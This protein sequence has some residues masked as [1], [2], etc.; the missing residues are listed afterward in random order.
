M[1]ADGRLVFT[2][3]FLLKRGTCCHLGCTNCPYGEQDE[4][5]VGEG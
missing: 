1:D 4:K 5:D 2:R 3:A